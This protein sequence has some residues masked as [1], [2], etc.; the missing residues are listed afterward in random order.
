MTTM[1]QQNATKIIN[2]RV[3]TTLTT[4]TTKKGDKRIE[5]QEEHHFGVGDYIRLDHPTSGLFEYHFVAKRGSLI[6]KDEVQQDYPINT[7]ITLI[8]QNATPRFEDQ[9]SQQGGPT[10]TSQ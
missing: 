5:V 7:G 2:S 10:N 6:L 8:V 3:R 9:G 4:T 1:L